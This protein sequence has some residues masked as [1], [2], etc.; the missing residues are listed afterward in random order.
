M[1]RRAVIA[2]GLVG[3]FPGCSGFGHRN[4]APS[5]PAQMAVI[6]KVSQAAQE[7]FDRQDW[8]LAQ[9]ELQRLVAEAPRSAEARHRLGRV[10][11]AQGR[12]VEAEAE[13]RKALDLD[14]E[15]VEA[16]VG[17]GQIALDAGRLVEA[18]RLLDQAIE[19]EPTR[20]EA[21]LGRGRTLEALGRPGEAL[22][23]Y[24]RAL[25]TSPDLATA[26]VRVATI[27]MEQ[28]QLDQALVR[29]DDVLELI[30]N[31]PE[32]HAL[33]GRV[34]LA[35]RQVKPAVD[36]LKFA[37]DRLPERPDV[38]FA[39]ALALEAAARQPDALKAAETASKLAPEWS[40]ARELSAKLRR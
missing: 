27:Q 14:K 20:A 24:F 40:E 18:L 10:L 35:L 16:I 22:A 30:P 38:F 6:Q 32:A 28:N 21:H 31:D 8:P 2:V 26:A 9:A 12:T 23:A 34:H 3:L 11:L 37:A 25:E 39:L 13:F 36:D 19:L 33:R 5:D 4:S 29:L 15:Y 1:R 17:L 7:A